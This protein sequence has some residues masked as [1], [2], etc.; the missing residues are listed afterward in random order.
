MSNNHKNVNT[1]NNTKNRDQTK[2]NTQTKEAPYT[3]SERAT[4]FKKY[5]ELKGGK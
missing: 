5:A 3:A 4:D 1:E 2:T